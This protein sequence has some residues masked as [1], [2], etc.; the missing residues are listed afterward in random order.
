V[1]DKILI[2]ED[3]QR[4]RRILKL[5][6]QD[7]G[8][9]VQTA[10]D[11]QAG[12]LCW[13]QWMPDVVL[14]D[15]KMKPVGGLEVLKFS[16]RHGLNAPLIVLTAFG[17]VE[18]AVVA[19]KEG[20]F[21]YLNKPVDNDKLLD[22]VGR[23]LA[24]RPKQDGISYEMIGTSPAMQV[25]R[26]DISLFAAGDS[27][28]L[29][30]GAS[31]TGKEL[32]ARAIHAA[33][34]KN[35]GPFIKVNCAAIPAELMESELFGYKRGA[36]TGASADFT[37]AFSRADGGILFLDEVGDL[38][39]PL[40]AKLLNAVEEKS[41]TPLG[42]GESMP[43]NI[44]ILSATNHDLKT[45]I[46]EKTFREDLYYRL[47]IVHIDM[48]LLRERTG[49]IDLLVNFFLRRFSR[50][51]N[52]TVPTITGEVAKLLQAWPW[53]GNVRELSNVVERAVLTCG[54][55]PVI[56]NHLPH[57]IRRMENTGNAKTQGS[58]DLNSH[59]KQLIISALKESDWNQTMA[60]K[61]LRIT[62]NT[63]RYRMK[64]FTINRKYR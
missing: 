51:S 8:Y 43:I 48:P 21:D 37:G 20:A 35:T 13:Q 5:V 47:N 2:I 50:L 17:T 63:L 41:I 34:P 52:K 15:L 58:M 55:G 10:A 26:R 57:A 56:L 22:L 53:P 18:T 62:R 64:K 3:E 36:F 14:T 40:Q 38:P 32:V 11:G 1:S 27:A 44:K 12:I 31:G 61:K 60:A 4:L 6:L 45:M 46:A 49:D 30:T 24:S 23:A 42:S 16:N 7:A 54:D 9:E 33:S 59:E 19:M 28:V 25:V 39:L 29:I